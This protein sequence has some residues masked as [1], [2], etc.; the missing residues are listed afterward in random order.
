MPQSPKWSFAFTFSESNF[1]FVSHFA[2]KE[3]AGLE[4]PLVRFTASGDLYM[5]LYFVWKECCK[6][7][8]YRAYGS[9]CRVG[10]CFSTFC[11]SWPPFDLDLSVW[12]PP[13]VDA[14]T[15]EKKLLYFYIIDLYVRIGLYVYFIYNI[16]LF[17]NISFRYNTLLP[18][19]VA[20]RSKA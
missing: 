4:K 9:V 8:K 14:L 17:L 18:I 20:V 3:D 11:C 13:F 10:Q 12:P 16:I 6:M 1:V 7:L 19:P 2:V 5:I 15:S